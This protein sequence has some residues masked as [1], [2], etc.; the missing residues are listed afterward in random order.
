MS[1]DPSY[2]SDCVG[3]GAPGGLVCVIDCPS[4]LHVKSLQG[5]Q[6]WMEE[7]W[8]E[9]R[10]KQLSSRLATYNDFNCLVSRMGSI[11]LH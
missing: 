5:E 1:D 4:S 6:T 8:V 7:Q 3:P 9:K 11:S 2:S 10:G